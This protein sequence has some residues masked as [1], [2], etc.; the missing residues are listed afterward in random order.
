MPTSPQSPETT[1]RVEVRL[2]AA[3]TAPEAFIEVRDV[4]VTLP[5]GGVLQ[6]VPT[7]DGRGLRVYATGQRAMNLLAQ[8]SAGNALTLYPTRHLPGEGCACAKGGRPCPPSP[9]SS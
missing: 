8:P 5:G 2:Q 1:F 3:Q 4:Q 6:L 9:P 7:D